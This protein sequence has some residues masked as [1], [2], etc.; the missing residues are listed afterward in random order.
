MLANISPA[1]AQQMLR[2]NKARLVDVR[3][4]DELAA[5]RIAGAEAAPLSVISWT[6]LG[7]G[8]LDLG[9]VMMLIPVV[10]FAVLHWKRSRPE[11][12]IQAYNLR[13]ILLVVFT[14]GS[15][16][17]LYQAVFNGLILSPNFQIVGN[18]SSA[19]SLNWYSDIVDGP[20]P[21]VG[22]L[23]LPLWVWRVVMLSWSCWLVLSLLGW[24]RW[25]WDSFSDIT[26]WKRSE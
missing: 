15:L 6:L 19:T 2:D 24:L 10:W 18:G 23:A 8:L 4:A 9:V 14:L 16:I 11:L 21:A 12:P 13:Q 20:T 17:C 1:D 7:F 25:S 3:E 22:F 26:F 5:V